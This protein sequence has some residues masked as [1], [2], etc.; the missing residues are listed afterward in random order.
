MSTQ[1]G[2][3]ATAITATG[4]AMDLDEAALYARAQIE[5]LQHR[6]SP[7]NDRPG[8]LSRREL[9]VLRLL[10]DGLTTREIAEALDNG[11]VAGTAGRHGES[12]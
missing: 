3:A 12:A 9:D 11:L 2:P 10:P 7:V 6:R 5:E 1:L 4:R 8:G